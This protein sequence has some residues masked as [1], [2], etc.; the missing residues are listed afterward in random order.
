ML[1]LLKKPTNDKP[2]CPDTAVL[3]DITITPDGEHVAIRNIRNF[4]YR[5]SQD[6]DADYYDRTF[7]LADLHSLDFFVEPF[8]MSRRT[9]REWGKAHTFVSFGI[10]DEHVAISIEVRRITGQRY[11]PISAL[12]RTFELIYVIA[13]ERDV[14]RLRSNIRRDA[15]YLY[16]IETTPAKLRALFMNMVTRAKTLATEPE[17]YN[18][19]TNTCTTNLVAHVNTIA[20]RRIPLRPQILLPG[21]CHK[22]IYDLGLIKTNLSY[23][24]THALAHINERALAHD[25][26]PEFSKAIRTHP[27]FSMRIRERRNFADRLTISQRTVCFLP[28]T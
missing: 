11:H 8:S 16:P 5:S 14:V 27:P 13:A 20:P 17:F 4:H 9:K 26:N 7:A 2:W 28:R 10:G 22:L 3:P 12:F 18:T 1:W 24:D 21:Y 15:V 25:E 19:L 23:V 6:F